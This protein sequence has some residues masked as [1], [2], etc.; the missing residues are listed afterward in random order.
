MKLFDF[1][2]AT[3]VPESSSMNPYEDKFKMSGAG[4]PR[5]MAPEVLVN[6]P[7]KYNLKAD[8]YTFGL[9]EHAGC[10]YSCCSFLAPSSTT[11]TLASPWDKFCGK[12]SAWSNLSRTSKGEMNSWNM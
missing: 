10:T 7:E 2:L 8:I 4:S 6:P 3:V 1:G 5:Y 9:G 12:Y 11:L